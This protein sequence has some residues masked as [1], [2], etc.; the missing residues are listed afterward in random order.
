MSDARL[1]LR[2]YLAL[3]SDE[4]FV[5]DDSGE[6]VSQSNSGQ[7]I[8]F[9]GEVHLALDLLT[10]QDLVPPFLVVLIGFEQVRD[11]VR[12]DPPEGSEALRGVR[13]Q[14][15]E[16]PNAIALAVVHLIE[17]SGIASMPERAAILREGLAGG[18]PRD[19]LAS[20]GLGQDVVSALRE[21]VL[22]VQESMDRADPEALERRIRAGFE[23]EVQPAPVEIDSDVDDATRVRRL[24]DELED[25]VA[26]GGVARL[27]RDLMAALRVPAPGAQPQDLPIGGYADVANRGEID[28]LLL[29]ELAQDDEVLASR[30]VL[31]EA[32]YLQREVPRERPRLDRTLLIDSGIRTWGVTRLFATAAALA[33]GAQTDRGASLRAL[34]ADGAARHPV[35][36]TGSAGVQEHM[37]ALTADPHPARALAELTADLTEEEGQHV[38]VTTRAAFRDPALQG[39]LERCAGWTVVAVDAEGTIELVELTPRG[40]KLLS[41]ARFDLDQVL[42]P[43]RTTPPRRKGARPPSQLPAYVR[44]MPSPL[45]PAFAAER[46]R[47]LDHE[48][49]KFVLTRD[50]RVMHWRRADEKPQWAKGMNA[51]ELAVLPRG[52]VLAF[53]IDG[54]GVFVAIYSSSR[55]RLTVARV[56]DE[57]MPELRSYDLDEVPAIGLRAD[58]CVVE[59]SKGVFLAGDDGLHPDERGGAK[60]C[61]VPSVVTL[62]STHRWGTSRL[63]NVRAIGFAPERKAEDGQMLVVGRCEW[64]LSARDERL[65]AALLNAAALPSDSQPLSIAPASIATFRPVVS[66]HPS[67]RFL[68]VVTWDDGSHAWM[69]RRGLLHLRSGD[70]AEGDVSILLE[71]DTQVSAWSTLGWQDGPMHAHLHTTLKSSGLHFGH[72]GAWVDRFA[73]RVAEATVLE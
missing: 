71:L 17:R 61:R 35:D 49:G 1:E 28:R 36:L 70:P 40:A 51:Y 21:A 69:D 27:A 68:S 2:R 22:I 7:T 53:Q 14:A 38:L 26:L 41:S 37:G 52:Q 50:R 10:N 29:S 11:F 59:T 73:Q 48:R 45:R 43:P 5:W 3:P 56:S 65:H 24:L 18:V 64:L 30:I 20:D 13:S 66:D 47:V 4:A 42:A 8:A 39:V 33:V 54:E 6:V 46:V 32:L 9:R 31:G 55:R 58:G 34:R 12:G 15:W 62:T 44:H 57:R 67:A 25:D 72:V 60:T 16:R 63:C 23:D 19:G